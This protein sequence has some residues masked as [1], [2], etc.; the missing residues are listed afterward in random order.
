MQLSEHFSLSEFTRSATATK[1]GIDN[2]P[3][4]E[5]IANLRRLC[6][7]VLEPLRRHFNVSIRISSGYRCPALNG[8]V[9]GVKNS[10]HL[11]GCAADIQPPDNAT[12]RKWMQWII[13][14][15][16]F[17]ECIWE[18]ADRKRYWIHVALRPDANRQK[19]VSFFLKRNA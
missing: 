8:A 17:D 19:V 14:N 3:N 18:T 9:G 5:Q 13:D 2:T 10:N 6:R 11:T 12:G 15:C 1:L 7:E 16:H 4:A